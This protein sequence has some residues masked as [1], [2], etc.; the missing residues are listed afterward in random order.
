MSFIA[1]LHITRSERLLLS[2]LLIIFLINFHLFQWYDQSYVAAI[3]Q[4]EVKPIVNRYERIQSEQHYY[5]IYQIAQKYKGREDLVVLIE[6]DKSSDNLDYTS[7]F[8]A[9]KGKLPKL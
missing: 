1:D 9:N 4:L 6:D 2:V 8:Y 3:K 5:E 7:R